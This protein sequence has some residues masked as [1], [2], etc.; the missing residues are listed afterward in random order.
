MKADKAAEMKIEWEARQREIRV[1]IG[2]G[3]P[4]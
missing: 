4:L 1:F 2:S 3:L